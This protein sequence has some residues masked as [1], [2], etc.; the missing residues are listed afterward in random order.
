M[1][2]IVPRTCTIEPEEAFDRRES[3]P[4]AEFRET[5]AYVLLGDPGSGKT[6]AF[7]AEKDELGNKA[8]LITARDLI[9]F[10][11]N[12]HPEWRDKTL[13][14]DGLDEVRAGQSDARTPFDAIRGRLDELGKP[15]FRLSCRS[16]DWLG[17]NDRTNLDAVSR[18]GKVTVLKLDPLSESDILNILDAY[19]DIDDPGAFV[20]EAQNRGVDGLL[21]NPQSLE[22]LI[23]L[24]TGGEDWPEG[25]RETF[26]GACSRMAAEQNA[27]HRSVVQSDTVGQLLDAAGRLC[28]LQLIAGVTGFASRQRDPEDDNL[29]VSQ[30][31]Y[32]DLTQLRH[33]LSTKLFTVDAAGTA[34][35]VHRH[36]AEYVGARHLARVIQKGLP[37][38]R[39]MALMT[40]EDGFVVTELRGLSAWLAAISEP[41][42]A[43]LIDLDPTGVGLYGDIRSFSLDDKSSI[44]TSL[45]DQVHRIERYFG[46]VPAFVDLSEP[47]MAPAIKE[48]LN[49]SDRSHEHQSFTAFLL[50][51][52]ALGQPLPELSDVLLDIMRDQSRRSDVRR[53]ALEAFANACQDNHIIVLT[54][55][56]LLA[57]I[58]SGTFEDPNNELL[59][60]ILSHTYPQHLPPSEVWDYLNARGDRGFF[61]SYH[62]FWRNHL[63]KKASDDQIAE[64]LDSLQGRLSDLRPALER[65]YLNE[66]LLDLLERGLQTRGDIME[67]ETLYDWLS[68]GSKL[69]K[70][71]RKGGA[72]EKIKTW[73]GQR[74]RIQKAVVAEGLSRCAETERFTFEVF[75]VYECLYGTELPSDFGLWCL[76]QAVAWGDKKPMVAEHLLQQAISA[77]RRQKCH[78]GLSIEL[79]KDQ[80]KGND[81]LKSKMALLL[82]LPPMPSRHE[83]DKRVRELVEQKQREELEWLD[84]VRSQ[85]EALRE[86]RAVHHLLFTLAESYLGDLN[87]ASGGPGV[88]AIRKLLDGDPELIG[89]ALQGL[90][91]VIDREDVPDVEKILNARDESRIYR[92]SLPF[93]AS[94][95]EIERTAPE[96]INLLNDSQMRKALAF[97]YSTNDSGD[98]PSWYRRILSKHPEI[99]AD[100]QMK[101]A[102]SAFKGDRGHIEGFWSLAH[103]REHSKVAQ[104][105]SLSL[106]RSFP[107]RCRSK[108][109][110]SLELLLWSAIHHSDRACLEKLIS[111]KNSLR[112]MNVS[113]RA[114]WLAAGLI[115]SPDTYL[116]SAEDFTAN[117][118]R[119]IRHLAN[120]FQSQIPA[121]LDVRVSTLL[122]RLEGISFGPDEM[123]AARVTPQ[124]ETP[125]TTGAQLVWD[126][127][128]RLSNSP[129]KDASDA[130]DGLTANHSLRH[131][132]GVLSS[133][134][135]SQRI[136]R[137]DASYRHPAVEQV[138]ATLNGSTPANAGDLAALLV[139]RFD[140]LAI[141]IRTSNTD[142]WHQYWNEDQYGR[143]LTPKH[144][145]HCRDAF[146]SGLRPLLPKGIDAQPEGQYAQDSRAD[147]RVARDSVFHVPVE[148][149]KNMHRDLWS[150]IHNQ[151]IA[152]YSSDPDSDGFGIYLVFWFGP[153]GTA[154]GPDGDRPSSASELMERLQAK[155]TR[156]QARKIS[157]CVVDVSSNR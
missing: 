115:T 32:E 133:A 65:H 6:T 33:A 113:Q 122:I 107:T 78:E 152:R 139:D 109:L 22:L 98:P 97:Y 7:Q 79:L 1:T 81:F 68:L 39:V 91:G 140:E 45:R 63:V 102:F 123:F 10:S 25:R 120:M 119:R 95:S 132:C 84:H 157:V 38:K 148:V 93:L 50:L 124:R 61:G 64:L 72:L 117:F 69:E 88:E 2:Y 5:V 135:D 54:F 129:D 49:E 58:K 151:L 28:A 42:R 41:A 101:F 59:G 116:K 19:P 24:V 27:E 31:G 155:L 8:H 37:P 26:E 9:A 62:V 146:L 104:M 128:Q 141:Q 105:V 55:R 111:K 94:M 57:R 134:R 96:E 17:A 156:D 30:C 47:L 75:D 145:E 103:D 110:E 46:A 147:I 150:A 80:T 153:N 92:I 138:C 149:K 73:L 74:P 154:V 142:D 67:L 126:L 112:S 44:L 51:I 13:F 106:L 11:P 70:V 76:S 125:A 3:R 53:S 21:T 99:V 60:A 100:V 143:T 144:E 86:N 87:R 43:T 127:I 137:R 77:H 40:G 12:D 108:Q 18:N 35:P 36:I 83:H 89:A 29:D 48:I 85:K 14:I 66:L 121:D 34:R 118:T 114:R 16:A 23:N 136:I 56:D 71:Q 90:R 82:S 15:D 131:W 4:L 20:K 130:L 52:L